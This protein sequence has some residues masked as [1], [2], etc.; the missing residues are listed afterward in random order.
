MKLPLIEGPVAQVLPRA[1]LQAYTFLWTGLLIAFDEA[2]AGKTRKPY[3]N[4][5][6]SPSSLHTAVSS[7]WP[8]KWNVSP[9]SF[10]TLWPLMI[11]FN[12]LLTCNYKKINLL[13]V[14]F[15][16]MKL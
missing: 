14:P 2:R 16:L 13:S 7:Q 1:D 8:A 10:S 5:S 15:E 6:S 9:F 4:T 11:V 12:K 3:S